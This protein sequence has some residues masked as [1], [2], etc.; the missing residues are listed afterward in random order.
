MK[1][2]T[3]TKG[4]TMQATAHMTYTTDDGIEFRW[5]GGEYIEIG[6]S[7]AGE[8]HAQDVINVWDYE[9]S[10]PYIPRTIEAFQARCD[11]YVADMDDES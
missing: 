7:E 4:H 11:E 9:T 10:S 8:W 2:S 5:H 6:Y 3:A 1:S